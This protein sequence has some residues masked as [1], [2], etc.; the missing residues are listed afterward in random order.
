MAILLEHTS[1]KWPFWLSP[2]QSVILPVTDDH[3]DY[4][5][6]VHAQLQKQRED[7]FN[8]FFV[9]LDGRTKLT[10]PK[11]IKE[12]QEKQYNYILVVGERERTE[13]TVS[14]RTRDGVI[15]GAK[16]TADLLTEW[17]QLLDAFQ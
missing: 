6:Q 2:R 16:T 14:V 11:R 1:G 8:E 3:Y 15:H 13:G 9:D 12:A 5:K 10:L 17:R 4:A 7:K